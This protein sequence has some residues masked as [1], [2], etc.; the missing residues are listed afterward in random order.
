[1]TNYHRI[2]VAG[3]DLAHQLAA[4][5]LF[6]VLFR[7]DQDL[8]TGIRA[9]KIVLP[10]GYQVVRHNDHGLPGKTEPFKLHDRGNH[11][12]GL[13]GTH[14][15]SEKAVTALDDAPDHVPLM[16]IQIVVTQP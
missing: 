13:A 14:R 5:V 9:E 16:R 15:M 7:R 10:L 1:M 6:E 11:F 4:I 3:R 12:E 8:S 2:I